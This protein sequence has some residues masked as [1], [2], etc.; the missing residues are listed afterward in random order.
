MDNSRYFLSEEAIWVSTSV[1]VDPSGNRVTYTGESHILFIND[2]IENRSRI[3]NGENRM[4]NNYEIRLISPSRYE[5]RSENPGLGIQTGYFDINGNTLYSK[6][7]ILNSDL[8]GFEVIIRQGN[9]CRAYGALYNKD[10]L[11]NS[12]N[13]EMKK[14]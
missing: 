13:A 12:W 11:I 4:E 7:S 14:R 6:F 8:N 1:F 5:Y 2:I 9:I 10:T 3:E